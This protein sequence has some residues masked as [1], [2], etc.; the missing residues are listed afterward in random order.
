MKNPTEFPADGVAD[1]SE[2]CITKRRGRPPGP[3]AETIAFRDA[4]RKI[5]E[6]QW[7]FTIRQAFY[8]AVV[9]C[10]VGKAE[11]GYDKVQ[12]NLLA[13]RRESMVPY[14][15]VV[16]LQRDLRGPKCWESTDAFIAAV[17]SMYRR[18]LW[19]DN[20]VRVEFWIEKAT[21]CGFLDPVICDR[22]G[23]T[24]WAGGGFTSETVLYKGGTAIAAQG[25]PTYIYTLSDFDPSGEDIANHIAHGNKQCP[26]GITRFTAG[27]PV[28]VQQLAVTKEQIRKW[29]LPTRPVVSRGKGKE[30]EEISSRKQRFI[31]EHGDAAVEL[32]AIPPNLL[33]DLIDKT[34]ASR[35]DPRKV[36]ELRSI[37][38]SE[39]KLL[40]MWL[41]SGKAQ[42]E[43]DDSEDDYDE[44]EY[45]EDDELKGM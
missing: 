16:D 38:K 27:V 2:A 28:Y 24:Y 12:R 6:T 40:P 21:L 45:D 14:E 10:L 4:L 5:L 44:D 31:D 32:D 34:I 22:W 36:D 26:G 29:Q 7:P 13:M 35:C 18:D 25:K 1:F 23:L 8:Q 39:R 41:K 33:R 42:Y 17:Q 37:E 30:P 43:A 15:W 19:R 9:A 3:T 11:T 20:P